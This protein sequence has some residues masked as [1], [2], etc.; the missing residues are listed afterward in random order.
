ML[1]RV[2]VIVLVVCALYSTVSFSAIYDNRFFPFYS[3]I[4]PRTKQK[5]SWFNMNAYFITGDEA[6]G[7]AGRVGIPELCGTF[8]QKL[9]GQEMENAGLPNPLRPDFQL[10]PGIPWNLCGK[11]TGQGIGFELEQAFT[12]RLSFGLSCWYLHTS[13]NVE[14]ILDKVLVRDLGF[15]NGKEGDLFEL[16]RELRQMLREIGLE[17]G[18]W[19]KSGVTDV[20]VYLRY[21]DIWDYVW[22]FRSVGAGIKLG[23]LAPSGPGRTPC[24]PA[25]IP[26]S[27]NKHLGVYGEADFQ[28]ELKEDIYF[29]GFLRVTGRLQDCDAVRFA[30]D[31]QT[32]LFGV[33]QST[34]DVDPGIGVAGSLYA[35]VQGIR[36]GLGLQGRYTIAYHGYDCLSNIELCE[37]LSLE[38]VPQSAIDNFIDCST[39]ISEYFSLNLFYDFGTNE[40]NCLV[41]SKFFFAWDIPIE[42][43]AAKNYVRTNRVALGVQFN[44]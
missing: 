29:G 7:V 5:Q 40:D 32:P 34:A 24:N 11:I 19:S 17:G 9:L 36:D 14:F 28:L 15:I 39:F 22:K 37:E 12:S 2:T 33:I 41:D 18:Q 10:L 25:S 21:G 4:F 30:N 43:F 23:V 20:D 6:E 44:Y 42:A 13:S 38:Q 26:F 31:C 8:D 27:G 1:R 16:D 3:Y 35:T